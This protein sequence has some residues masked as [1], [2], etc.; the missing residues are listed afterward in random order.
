MALGSS[1][2]LSQEAREELRLFESRLKEAFMY[3]GMLQYYFPHLIVSCSII[4]VLA[5]FVCQHDTSWG[6][7]RKRSFS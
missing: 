4:A 6:Y 5:G 1:P 3:H 7:H 2:L